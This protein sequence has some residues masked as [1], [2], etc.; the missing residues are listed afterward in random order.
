MDR[1]GRSSGPQMGSKYPHPRE[2]QARELPCLQI[3]LVEDTSGGCLARMSGH[4]VGETAGALWSIEPMM[5]N[6]TRVVLDLSG[7]VTIDGAGLEATIRLMDAIRSFG[8]SLTIG[9]EE[10][11]VDLVTESVAP[12]TVSYRSSRREG[13]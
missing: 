4:L 5:A 8:G 2:M 10:L 6:E 12:N 11:S 13:L 1:Y 7:V 9:R 3:E